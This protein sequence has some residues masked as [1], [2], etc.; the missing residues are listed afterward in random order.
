MQ[1]YMPIMTENIKKQLL[2][3]QKLLIKQ[4]LSVNKDIYQ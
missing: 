3:Q 4:T 1:H 2:D